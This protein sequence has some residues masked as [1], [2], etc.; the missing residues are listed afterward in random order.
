MSQVK[1]I[2]EAA[3]VSWDDFE[4]GCLLTYAGGHHND[5]HLPAFQHGMRTVFSLLR[6]E[7]PPAEICKAAGELVEPAEQALE[8]LE[9][10]DWRDVDIGLNL[11]EV[12]N[13]LGI[14][15]VKLRNAGNRLIK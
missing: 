5:S 14:A 7:F 1:A 8:I 3:P 9:S 15:L 6:A 10:L 4:R 12:K 2:N 13:K 11:R